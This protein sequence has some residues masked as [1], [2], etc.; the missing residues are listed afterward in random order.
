MSGCF[1]ITDLPIPLASKEGLNL[2]QHGSHLGSWTLFCQ[3]SDLKQTRR[4]RYLIKEFLDALCICYQ[5]KKMI[6][7]SIPLNIGCTCP[8]IYT[9]LRIAFQYLTLF[10]AVALFLL[11]ILFIRLLFPN[12]TLTCQGCSLW[13]RAHGFYNI[14]LKYFHIL[15][16]L[17]IQIGLWMNGYDFPSVWFFTTSYVLL[18]HGQLLIGCIGYHSSSGKCI[19]VYFSAIYEARLPVF[20]LWCPDTNTET[21]ANTRVKDKTALLEIYE[22]NME[23][24]VLLITWNFIFYWQILIQSINFLLTFLN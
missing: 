20:G 3:G 2:L 21:D 7:W 11:K 23:M 12:T 13:K 16:Y 19:A 8:V 18:K 4:L 9:D 15:K 17:G 5:C 22:M 14:K 10:W 1:S 24:I 6:G